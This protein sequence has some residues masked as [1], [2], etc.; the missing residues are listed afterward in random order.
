MPRGNNTATDLPAAPPTGPV[1]LGWFVLGLLACTLIALGIRFYKLE[2]G[3]FW[4]DELYTVMTAADFEGKNLSKRLGY[5]PTRIAMDVAGIDLTTLDLT[6]PETWIG[7][8]ITERVLRV[9]HALIGALS[10][11]LLVLAARRPLGGR[12]ALAFGLLLAISQWHIYWSQAARFYIVQ[13]VFFSLALLLW[14]DST[15]PRRPVLYALAM[16]CA[17][18][19][20]W[21]QPHALL[22]FAVMGADWLVSI[23]RREPL[24]LAW[25]QWGLGVLS[26]GACATLQGIDLTA[27]TEQWAQFFGHDR[28]L[29]PDQVLL[30]IVYFVWPATAAFAGLAGLWMLAAH[31]RLGVLLVVGAGLP[32]AV[33]VALSPFAFIGS[34]YAFM[35]LGPILAIAGA[36][37]V[38]AFDELR[39]RTGWLLAA[40]LPAAVVTGQL[41]A[42]AI[43][44]RSGGNFHAPMRDVAAFIAA[45]NDDART[46]YAHEHGVIR[47]YTRTSHA[48]FLPRTPEEVAAIA[49]PAWFVFQVTHDGRPDPRA[50]VP[51][52]RFER[53]FTLA[54]V[55]SEAGLDVYSYTPED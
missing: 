8:G 14:Y 44:F 3:S 4:N 17:F 40:A 48:A 41:F 23:L 10:V 31:R 42:T 26:F 22:V 5:V 36:A 53:R 52:M 39:P 46:V 13:F 29:R 43:Y 9:P 33:F 34:R 28:W 1:P 47:Y 2:A 19:A 27:R 15:R 38:C 35:C 16:L 37:M 24:R 12:G 30:G 20:F 54:Q 45:R 50:E 21:S 11:P 25:W 18:L 55:H 6:R 7:A 32:I 51:G 49:D